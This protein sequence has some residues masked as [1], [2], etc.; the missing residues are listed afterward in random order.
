MKT[1]LCK[2]KLL[3]GKSI[4][5]S[6]NKQKKKNPSNNCLKNPLMQIS[7]GSPFVSLCQVFLPMLALPWGLQRCLPQLL[8]GLWH[9][10]TAGKMRVGLVQKSLQAPHQWC[11]L[12][13]TCSW[14]EKLLS[15]NLSLSSSL[16]P[17]LC[18]FQSINWISHLPCLE[19]LRGKKIK[20]CNCFG[21]RFSRWNNFSV[22]DC[23]GGGLGR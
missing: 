16:N 22:Y 8:Q 7:L 4:N 12:G 9:Q 21:T 20:G 18:V 14:G 10:D 1:N 23:G 2:C 3:P 6:G 17:A 13:V 15:G 5:A 19:T 11:D